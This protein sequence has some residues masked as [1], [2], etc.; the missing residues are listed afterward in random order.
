MQFAD[1]PVAFFADDDA[2]ASALGGA[3]LAAL[4]QQALAYRLEQFLPHFP[5]L[6]ALASALGLDASVA[7][8]EAPRLFF[9]YA[10][11]KAYD[12]EWLLHHDFARM[13]RWLQAFTTCNLSGGED[14]P[15]ATVDA[16]LDWLRAEKRQDVLVSSGTS[17]GSSL[18][19]LGSAEFPARHRRIRMMHAD[20]F[21]ERGV[22]AAAAPCEGLVWPAS[23]SGNSGLSKLPMGFRDSG[24]LAPEAIVTLYERDLGID[25]QLYVTLAHQLQARGEQR[26]PAPSGYV[27][28]K[29]EEAERRRRDYPQDLDAMLDRVRDRLSG[30][31]VLIAG[32]PHS[33]AA[34]AT[35]A[36]GRGMA[37]TFATYTRYN[38]AGGFKGFSA[39]DNWEADIRRF[40]GSDLHIEAYGMSELGSSFV[41]CREGRFHLPPWVVVW[42]L[43]PA[44]GWQPFPREGRH[45]GRGAFLDLSAATFWG[46]VVSGDHLEVSY[47]PCG[48]GRATPSFDRDIKRVSDADND[49]SY[50]PASPG[51]IE[52]ALETLRTG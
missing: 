9:P 33:L 38:T 40:S 11:Y 20:W 44:N 46:G 18:V 39:P 42:V 10:F 23:G 28:A 27:E 17:G 8:D 5:P 43:D 35:R 34:L 14:Q 49:C 2:A 36:I 24:D 6:A 15:F 21:A 19:A 16:W 4:Q 45:E 48:C 1:D 50:T 13:T 37:G 41:A 51:A 30:R 22:P 52:A 12:P 31:R 47:E 32:G 25:Y 7:L 26:M 29:L 3:E